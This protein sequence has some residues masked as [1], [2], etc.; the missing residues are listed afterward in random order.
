MV[1][2]G[3][4]CARASNVGAVTAWILRMICSWGQ[5]LDRQLTARL[6]HL[7]EQIPTEPLHD[8]SPWTAPD[9]IKE[10]S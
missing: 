8:G 2:D 6:K 9:E 10:S 4:E 1:H 3:P 7:P 5:A